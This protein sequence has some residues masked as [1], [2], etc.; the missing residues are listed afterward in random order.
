MKNVEI[1]VARVRLGFSQTDL[2][3]QVG[4]SK[5]S[6]YLIEA[7]KMQPTI[8]VAFKIAEVL[9]TNVEVLF[10]LEKAD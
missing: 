9:H 3:E 8:Q 6:I 1:K 5:N 10:K 4:I 2:A 7:G